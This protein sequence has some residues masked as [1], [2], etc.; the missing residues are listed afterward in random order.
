MNSSQV[1]IVVPCYNES[2]RLDQQEF[3]RFAEEQPG[4]D[5]LFVDDGSQDSTA[6]VLTALE[7]KQNGRF[8]KLI[9]EK[10]G[11]KAEAVRRGFLEV[12]SSGTSFVGFWDADL[13]TPL[14]V[15]PHFL[16]IYQEIPQTQMVIGSR[17]KLM[18]HD[19]QRNI[20]RHYAGRVFATCASL[21]LG[22]EVYDTQCG[23]K[24]FRVT[25]DLKQVFVQP[26]NSRWIFDVEILARFLKIKGWSAKEAESKI[27]ELPLRKWRDV[28][29]S[30][31]KPSDFLKAFI[32]L[33]DLCLRYRF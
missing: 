10:N 26:F 12:M 13:A 33:F 19:I 28:H 17:V 24:I 21:V 32:E 3:I 15:L 14:E 23:A 22:L 25:E 8:R 18:G 7:A 29:G 16:R 2:A 1:V 31:V 9:L 20:L 27:Y 5:F 6:E 30:K 4:Y 11:G